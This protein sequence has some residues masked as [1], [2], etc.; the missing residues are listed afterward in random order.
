MNRLQY[1]L[2]KLAEECSEVS[3]MA[4]KCAHHGIDN[5]KPEHTTPNHEMLKGELTDVA[6]IVD[7]L[8]VEFKLDLSPS[9]AGILKKVDKVNQFY[10]YSK[11]NGHVE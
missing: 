7:M 5:I 2:I 11:I 1:L 6:A 3:Q 4:L 9:V 10:G 8:E